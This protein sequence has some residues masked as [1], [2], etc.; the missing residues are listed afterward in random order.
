MQALQQA[1]KL[2]GARKRFG[3]ARGGGADGKQFGFFFVV[4]FALNLQNLN[5]AAAV[6]EATEPPDS[7]LS[8]HSP[9]PPAPLQQP[10]LSSV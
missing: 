1:G 6:T 4:F 3:E 9:P 10:R 8:L 7:R 5:F 2:W